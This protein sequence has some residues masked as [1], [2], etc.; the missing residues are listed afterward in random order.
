MRAIVLSILFTSTVV[1]AQAPIDGPRFEVVSIKRNTS[2]SIFSNGRSERPDG[3]FTLVNVP[4]M[5]LVGRAQFSGIAPIDMVGL[6]DCVAR[7]ASATG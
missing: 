5:T 3:G 2:N 1:L 6:P 7:C 4:M